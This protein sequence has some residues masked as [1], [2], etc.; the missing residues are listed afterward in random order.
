M[1]G[2]VNR[3]SATGCWQERYKLRRDQNKGSNLWQRDRMKH[4]HSFC[5]HLPGVINLH[6]YFLLR[7]YKWQCAGCDF[8]G[9]SSSRRLW[10]LLRYFMSVTKCCVFQ[11]AKY[12]TLQVQPN[13]TA[14]GIPKPLSQGAA[15]CLL[16]FKGV[17][18]VSAE[19]PPEPSLNSTR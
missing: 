15:P 1:P 13:V 12:Q 17:T 7:L 14:T 6:S 10:S 8:S 18:A 2:N 19:A 4:W 16:H 11:S 5:P 3:P 9:T